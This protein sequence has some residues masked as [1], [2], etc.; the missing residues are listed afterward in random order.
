[1]FEYSFINF[2]PREYNQYED[3][4]NMDPKIWPKQRLIRA[5]RKLYNIFTPNCTTNRGYHSANSPQFVLQI[6]E[7]SYK[8]QELSYLPTR[9]PHY[10][11]TFWED[12]IYW[13]KTIVLGAPCP[14]RP[15][16]QKSF[17]E[18]RVTSTYFLRILIFIEVKPLFVARISALL[19]SSPE[20]QVT[21]VTLSKNI[22]WTKSK[23][24]WTWLALQ[25]STILIAASVGIIALRL[26]LQC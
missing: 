25:S 5:Q 20:L 13:S 26:W 24:I 18:H 8:F 7:L 3:D 22:N 19:W 15:F 4:P 12:W 14:C 17:I 21:S 23:V 2:Y 10:L 11:H 1:M 9:Y 16:L 6:T